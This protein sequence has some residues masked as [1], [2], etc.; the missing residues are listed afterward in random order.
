MSM[1]EPHSIAIWLPLAVSAGAVAATI[2]IHTLAVIATVNF[3]RRERRLGHVGAG[4]WS[5]LSIVGVTI[6]V[7]FAAHL[8][9]IG[10]W[11]ALF[12]LCG[13]FPAFAM[14]YDHSAVN[15]TTLGY[16]DL[17]MTPPW[18]VLGPLEAAIGMLM[19]GVTTALVFAVI[20]RLLH[21]RFADLRD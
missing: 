2:A 17:I 7:A 18:R 14:A 8:V 21:S 12:M 13:E 4:F 9:E 6:S 5:D 3:V 15:Y 16:G 11:A 10:V 19:F 20:Q 1:G